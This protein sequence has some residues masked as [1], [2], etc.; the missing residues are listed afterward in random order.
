MIH[1]KRNVTL[2]HP[3]ISEVLHFPHFIGICVGVNHPRMQYTVRVTR[4]I[5]P[6][7]KLGAYITKDW[8]IQHN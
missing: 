3:T 7:V 2:S 4:A 6:N 8:S 5:H 1:E